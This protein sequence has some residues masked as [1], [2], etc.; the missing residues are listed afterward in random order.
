MRFFK[1]MFLREVNSELEVLRKKLTIMNDK[2]QLINKTITI[3]IT[4]FEGISNKVAY[5]IYYFLTENETKTG[6]S[7][8]KRRCMIMDI[9][10]NCNDPYIDIQTYKEGDYQ[11]EIED[12]A[13]YTLAVYKYLCIIKKSREKYISD[14]KDDIDTASSFYLN[15]LNKLFKYCESILEKL[16]DDYLIKFDTNLNE[17]ESA[18]IDTIYRDALFKES[19]ILSNAIC[20]ADLL[21]E[22][23]RIF[24]N[25]IYDDCI[26]ELL[27]VSS[28]SFELR[29]SSKNNKLNI[30]QDDDVFIIHKFMHEYLYTSK[31]KNID[32]SEFIIMNQLSSIVINTKFFTVSDID[33]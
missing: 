19:Q 33:S 21:K 3:D 17:K 4:S 24:A 6:D 12:V 25:N 10:K 18:M 23:N 27:A 29:F 30:V 11:R 15:E 9:L 31:Y 8:H 26:Y 14:S 13:S 7:N 32:R 5:D 28:D 22:K 16:K 2:N 20:D 1:N